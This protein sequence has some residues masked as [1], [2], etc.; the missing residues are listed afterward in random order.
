VLKRQRDSRTARFCKKRNNT[1]KRPDVCSCP[2]PRITVTDDEPVNASFLATILQ[3][4]GLY[5]EF[6]CSPQEALADA[7]SKA[8]DSL[9]SGVT[10]TGY[11]G[12]CAQMRMLI[13]NGGQEIDHAYQE[14]RLLALLQRRQKLPA[15]SSQVADLDIEIIAV[16]NFVRSC[17]MVQARQYVKTALDHIEVAP[18]DSAGHGVG[19]VKNSASHTVWSRIREAPAA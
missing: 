10:S 7:Q 15:T 8:L 2:A 19:G 6:F 17:R 14:E 4:N 12:G 16:W 9:V 1:R 13:K 5:A 3:R 18:I 11:F